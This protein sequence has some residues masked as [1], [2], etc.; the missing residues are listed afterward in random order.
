M[1]FLTARIDRAIV[2]TQYDLRG[3]GHPLGFRH[4]YNGSPKCFY[5]IAFNFFAFAAHAREKE[6]PT[7]PAYVSMHQQEP[8]YDAYLAMCQ[9]LKRDCDLSQIE[10]IQLLT[11]QM[12][13]QSREMQAEVAAGTRKL[14]NYLKP[15]DKNNRW[16]MA[17]LALAE[18]F[19]VNLKEEAY[20]SPAVSA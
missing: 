11:K 15:L 7:D 9:Q 17:V 4:E 10:A 12:V 14:S 13:K 1:S 5:F 3:F 18:V 8:T 16:G 6:P 20:A 2:M 19:D